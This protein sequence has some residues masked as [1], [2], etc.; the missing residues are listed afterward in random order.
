MW[1]MHYVSCL[2]IRCVLNAFPFEGQKCKNKLKT[3]PGVWKGQTVGWKDIDMTMTTPHP[4]LPNDILF[5]QWGREICFV[6][7]GQKCEQ[8]GEWCLR[9]RK[10][11]RARRSGRKQKDEIVW[12][13]VFSKETLSTRGEKVR[14]LTLWHIS[15]WYLQDWPKENTRLK[16]RGEVK[17]FR[18]WGVKFWRPSQF[19]TID[20]GQS[21]RLG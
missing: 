11:I 1:S 19:L 14:E 8:K 7:D 9:A 5:P 15:S 2:I 12:K 10:G 18:I 3:S 13:K 6:F 4:T 17:M 16:T 21:A 20:D